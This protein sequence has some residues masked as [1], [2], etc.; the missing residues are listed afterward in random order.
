MALDPP[1][2]LPYAGAP[3]VVNSNLTTIL[4]YA[5]TSYTKAVQLADDLRSFDY[6]T[7]SAYYTALPGPS[8]SG[9]YSKP[10]A[11]VLPTVT[12]VE[13]AAPSPPSVNQ[14]SLPALPSAPDFSVAPP[15]LDFPDLPAP[16]AVTAPGAVPTLAT[17]D[18]PTSPTLTF[19]DAPNLRQIILP[20]APTIQYPL[21]NNPYPDFELSA[22]PNTFGFSEKGYSSAGLAQVQARI[23]AMLQGGT[24]LPL[25]IEQALFDR[26]RIRED[27]ASQKLVM[28]ATEEFSSRGFVMPQGELQARIREARETN[29]GN[30]NSLNRDITIQVHQ[31]EIENMR[32]AVSQ[33]IALE[34]ALINLYNSIQQRAF[35]AA[36]VTVEVAINLFNASIS[37]QNLRLQGFQAK[38]QVY[39]DQI[40]A[41]GLKLEVYRSQLEGQ[42]LISELNL[43]DVQIYTQR[44]QALTTQIEVYRAQIEA[45]RVATETDRIRIDAYRATV[46]AYSAQV[47]AKRTEFEA[48]A[49]AIRGQSLKVSAYQAQAG[50]YDSLVRAYAAR[51]DAVLATPRLQNETNRVILE[52]YQ[53]NTGAY[54][55]SIDAQAKKVG[56]QAEIYRGQATA[57]AAEIE[58]EKAR[59]DSFNSQYGLFTARLA[60][61]SQVATEFVKIDASQLQAKATLLQESLK[62]AG[63]MLAQLAA[64][65]IS[66]INIGASISGS[67]A[68]SFGV[69]QSFN[70]D[71][72]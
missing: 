2:I 69:S 4:N 8:L 63:Q 17:H 43:Q 62:N 13:T 32:F 30:A 52:Q 25:F 51:V 18:L 24:G 48:Y 21:L 31:V 71:I 11:P 57:Y 34:G 61:E 72:S 58:A 28:E 45:V 6:S 44:L 27:K 20:D 46:D 60:A 36:R 55:A 26:A 54:V 16:I 59:I 38:A 50:A 67:D 37:L 14:P 10:P 70:K 29:R 47:G 68:N 64:S 23:S 66:A 42:K 1:A 5:N 65:S 9:A 33:G 40:Q 41:E 56:A 7:T 15:S 53:A 39:R 35:E 49:E 3:S 12:F 22:P 19:P